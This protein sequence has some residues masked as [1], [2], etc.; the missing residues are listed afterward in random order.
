LPIAEIFFKKRYTTHTFG[1]EICGEFTLEAE[2]QR[3]HFFAKKDLLLVDLVQQIIHWCGLS[4]GMLILAS[5]VQAFLLF[6]LLSIL[7]FLL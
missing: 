1:E 7:L 6:L 2:G 5:L 4:G 3:G